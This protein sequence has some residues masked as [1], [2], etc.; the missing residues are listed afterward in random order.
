MLLEWRRA[1][2]G[3]ACGL[4][5]CYPLAAIALVSGSTA[6]DHVFVRRADGSIVQT[7]AYHCGGCSVMFRDPEKFAKQERVE[8]VVRQHMQNVTNIHIQRTIIQHVLN[9]IRPYRHCPI[10]LKLEVKARH[11]P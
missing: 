3:R 11:R 2:V 10:R 7:Q 9:G 8:G 4:L 5:V 1:K 6:Y